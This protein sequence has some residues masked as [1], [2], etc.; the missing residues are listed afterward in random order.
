MPVLDEMENGV[1]NSHVDAQRIRESVSVVLWYRKLCPEGTLG[2]GY[3][4][5][6]GYLGLRELGLG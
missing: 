6:V 4:T 3:C 1:H 5:V 2:I